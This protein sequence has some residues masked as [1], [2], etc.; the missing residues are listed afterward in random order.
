M[1][2]VE[3]E[4][5]LAIDDG[6]VGGMGLGSGS[7]LGTSLGSGPLLSDGPLAIELSLALSRVDCWSAASE[8]LLSALS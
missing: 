8:V 6:V 2:V 1:E 4:L 3:E 5:T 7:H